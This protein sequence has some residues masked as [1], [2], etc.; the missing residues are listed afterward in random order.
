MK[1]VANQLDDAGLQWR[2][3]MEDM[4]TPCER[5]P[6]GTRDQ[7]QRATIDSQYAVRHN[8]FVYFRS[9]INGVTCAKNDVPLKRAAQGPAGVGRTPNF[10][11]IT[12]TCAPTVT[13]RRASTAARAG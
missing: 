3:Y 7:T 9:I 2:G 10:A 13:T 5:P 1:T 6:I 4:R 11:L 8:P 12:P